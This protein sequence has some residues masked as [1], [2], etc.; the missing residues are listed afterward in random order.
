MCSLL[1]NNEGNLIIES[2]QFLT[3]RLS[4]IRKLSGN[5]LVS[6]PDSINKAVAEIN[7]TICKSKERAFSLTCSNDLLVCYA[8]AMDEKENSEQTRSIIWKCLT[9]QIY[10]HREDLINSYWTYAIQRSA[11][12][13]NRQGNQEYHKRYIEFHLVLGA[14]LLFH[15]CDSLLS[16]MLFRSQTYPPEYTLIPSNFSDVFEWFLKAYRNPYE[17]NFYFESK[18]PFLND[19]DALSSGVIRRYLRKYIAL[20]TLRLMH[21]HTFYVYDDVS[22]F[23]RDFEK[24]PR[25]I[26]CYID[27]YKVLKKEADEWLTQ[28]ERC[29]RLLKNHPFDGEL[30][31]VFKMLD[32]YNTYLQEQAQ[33]IKETQ[34]F[35][36]EII[37]SYKQ[38]VEKQLDERIGDYE[39]F[40]NSPTVIPPETS[41]LSLSPNDASSQ[42]I[43]PSSYFKKGQEVSVNG[44]DT[45]LAQ[46]VYTAMQ[47]HIASLFF[48]QRILKSV[49]ADDVLKA[50]ERLNP[51]PDRHLILCL[52]Y[53]GYLTSK[54]GQGNNI[55]YNFKGVPIYLFP[56]SPAI[57]TF[58]LVIDKHRMPKI[59]F[60]TPQPDEK[61][62]FHYDDKISQ[63]YPVYW[64][65]TNLNEKSKLKTELLSNKQMG[66]Y[67]LNDKSY[68]AI[69]LRYNLY[70]P[71]DCIL[72]GFQLVNSYSSKVNELDKLEELK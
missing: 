34:P 51:H 59:Q 70:I 28:S 9:E 36:T 32:E 72:G 54:L 3:V 29:E 31:D 18:Y 53:D 55:S 4:L 23:N 2:Y 71:E 38:T 57:D 47:H 39:L 17:D 15:E 5:N 67:L 33:H 14:H 40:L 11:L 68:L 44:F 35:S 48:A 52:G 1:Q 49:Y 61:E 27:A 41:P 12:F 26:K 58:V 37:T 43:Y 42:G 22:A 63:L 16:E 10:R 20:L 69:Y 65:L 6:Y 21:V 45:A 66:I 8:G 25:G 24:T 62:L 13:L 19:K 7:S 60:E 56:G 50:L 30:V 46:Q 64:G